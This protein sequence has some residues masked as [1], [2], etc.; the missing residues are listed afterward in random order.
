MM[1]TAPITLETNLSRAGFTLVEIALVI[2][3]VGIILIG[4]LATLRSVL[5]DVNYRTT[6]DRMDGVSKAI[7][8]Y[9]HQ[10]YYLPCPAAQPDVNGKT[11][12]QEI[13]GCAARGIVPYAALNLRAEQARDSYGRYM[14]YVVNPSLAS[15]N[16][17]TQTNVYN[18]CR[19]T[20]LWISQTFTAS[21]ILA[22]EFSKNA[23]KA[24]FCCAVINTAN[25]LHIRQAAGQPDMGPI[26]VNPGTNIGNVNWTSLTG[27][28]SVLTNNAVNNAA[29][30]GYN[31]ATT[32]FV[33][34]SHG[35]NGYGAYRNGTGRIVG[36][37]AGRDAEIENA[38]DTNNEYRAAPRS[39]NATNYFDDI[40]LWRTQDQLISAL[41]RDSCARP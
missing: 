6:Q 24:R 26:A 41:G 28:P 33:L 29:F 19:A 4:G 25:N 5:D 12:G 32:A 8:L 23:I 22:D 27:P 21:I 38:D 34:I 20:N 9:V 37:T 1:R 17:Q 36:P 14:T 18:V 30:D 10:H 39:T 11:T 15:A 40:L 3:I 31:T 2:G 7:G 16:V 13:A 35:K